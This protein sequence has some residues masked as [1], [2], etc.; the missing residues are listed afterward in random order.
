MWKWKKKA[1]EL[2]HR[3]P[4]LVQNMWVNTRNTN[5]TNENTNLLTFLKFIDSVRS[6]LFS[7]TLFYIFFLFFFC[8]QKK[9]RKTLSTSTLRRGC[10]FY[11]HRFSRVCSLY[12]HLTFSYI[13]ITYVPFFVNSQKY[14]FPFAGQY[15]A[16]DK[17]CVYIFSP[18]SLV[19]LL[20]LW[21]DVDCYQML[22]R[23]EFKITCYKFYS[24]DGMVFFLLFYFE[25][26][27]LNSNDYLLIFRMVP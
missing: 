6:L 2:Y 17:I 3:Q 23:F 11:C 21:I 26:L 1:E 15:L 27:R 14:F 7:W 12:L 10:H 9:S 24:V 5:L 22:K 18:F 13:H 25:D 19:C 8:I 16:D 20:Y 4:K